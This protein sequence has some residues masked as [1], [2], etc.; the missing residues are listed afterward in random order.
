MK[1]IIFVNPFLVPDESIFQAQ[2]LRE[3]FN[4]L[5]V[6]VEIISNGF[7]RVAL[8]EFGAKIDI[9]KPDFAVY[10]DKDKYLSEILE[11]SG[12]RLFNSH[13]AVRVC[14]DK[15]QTYIALSGCGITI[16]KTKVFRCL[17]ML[18]AVREDRGLTLAEYP[19]FLPVMQSPNTSVSRIHRQTVKHRNYSYFGIFRINR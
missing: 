15:A 13:N 10:L 12:I 19:R 18:R 9:E 16:P 3:E 11:K 6:K 8:D 14:D 5:G 1:G 17:R 4:N 7:S 2:R